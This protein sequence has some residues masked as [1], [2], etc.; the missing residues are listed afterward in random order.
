MEISEDLL[1]DKFGYFLEMLES[2]VKKVE[3]ENS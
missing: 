2:I 3:E 1:L